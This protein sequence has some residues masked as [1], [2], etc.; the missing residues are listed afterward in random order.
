[1]AA[2]VFVAYKVS[3]IESRSKKKSV[4][5]SRDSTRK[6]KGIVFC[7]PCCIMVHSGILHGTH[8]Y[9]K[10]EFL[11]TA[12]VYTVE[13]RKG[14]VGKTTTAITLGVGLAQRLHQNGG[15]N[16]LIIDMD[17]QGDAARGLGLD[18]QDRCVSNVLLGD[19]G[20]EALRANVMP[21]DRSKGGGPSRPNLYIMPASDKLSEAKEDILTQFALLAARSMRSRRTESEHNLVNI[22]DEKLGL[23]KQA[24]RYIII[25][26]PPTLDL[27]QQAV[28]QYADYAV[29]P[30]KVDFHGASATGRHTNNILQDQ[31]EGIDITIAA[32]VPTFVNAHHNLTK[33]MMQELIR[34]YG[35][36]VI[37]KAVPNTVKVAEAPA[38][39]GQTIIEYL[40]DSTAAIAYQDLVDRIYA[41]D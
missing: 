36:Q 35:K 8:W 1:L 40:P 6:A 3:P 37:A 29:V 32:I 31:A 13:N 38:S 7:I 14:G 4:F 25:D 30:V 5:I 9:T 33:S 17:P 41:Q 19:G 2:I 28:H 27:L 18:P 12:K 23:A 15:G 10:Q 24:F 16:A 26:C 21:A 20:L 22:L 39:G 34:V 11:M